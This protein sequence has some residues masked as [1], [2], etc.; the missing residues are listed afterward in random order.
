MQFSNCK[1]VKG[2]MLWKTL[3]TGRFVIAANIIGVQR[4]R[5]K[6]HNRN[7][8]LISHSDHL[9]EHKHLSQKISTTTK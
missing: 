2:S 3:Y 4:K 1:V 8:I 6:T 7:T 9:V 5:R